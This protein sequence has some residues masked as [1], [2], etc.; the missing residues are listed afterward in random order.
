MKFQNA[1]LAVNMYLGYFQML[2]SKEYSN[3]F[4]SK[5]N[6]IRLK[7]TETSQKDEQFLTVFLSFER[8]SAK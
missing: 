4:H 5:E 8:T 3:S 2:Q 7:N 1:E 6:T